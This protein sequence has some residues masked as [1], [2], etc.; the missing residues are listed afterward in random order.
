MAAIRCLHYHVECR[1]EAHDIARLSDTLCAVSLLA[2]PQAIAQA[3]PAPAGKPNILFIMGDDIGWMQPSIYHRGLMVGETPNIDRVA[4]L[5]CMLV[6]EFRAEATKSRDSAR[7]NDGKPFLT[8]EPKV[9]LN[10]NF[11]GKPE[12][13]HL[14]IGRRPVAAFGNSIGDRQMLEYS[15]AGSGARLS[16]IVLH[17]DAVREYAY[18]PAQGLPDWTVDT[19]TQAL[20][21][22]AT[23]SG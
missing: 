16:M 11:A 21:D 14:M 10:D 20:Y 12:G 8:K 2:A 7:D 22:E 6:E 17:D 19:F 13:I 18:G 1:D 9:L 23:K 15:K 5:S 3:P 4:T